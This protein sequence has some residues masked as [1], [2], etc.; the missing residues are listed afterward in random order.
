[1]S[2][3]KS[4]LIIELKDS[5]RNKDTDIRL[6]PSENDLMYWD[7]EI[8]GPDETPYEGFVFKIEII[9]SPQYPILPPSVKFVTPIFHPNVNFFTG[10][11]CI[12]VIKDNWTPAWTLHAVCRAIISILCDP[13]PNSPLNCDAG[14]ILRCGDKKGFNNMARMYSLEYASKYK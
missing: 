12:D 8:V 6:I 1:M 14:N 7:G 4:R 2:A 3:C 9:V 13:N 10:E 5:S 11:V